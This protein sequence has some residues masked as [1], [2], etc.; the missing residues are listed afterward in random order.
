MRLQGFSD[1][2]NLVTKKDGTLSKTLNWKISGN[3]I[4]VTVVKELLYQLLYRVEN[5]IKI[6]SKKDKRP[7][8]LNPSNTI[9]EY[10][11]AS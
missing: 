2:F 10:K 6:S 8:L 1:N 4:P 11:K 9:F 3:T 5:D 7:E